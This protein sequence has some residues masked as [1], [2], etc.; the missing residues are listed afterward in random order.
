M[1]P[2]P[3]FFP[4]IGTV[5]PK[6]TATQNP[7]MFLTVTC[8]TASI[9]KS[10]ACQARLASDVEEPASP[11]VS[12]DVPLNRKQYLVAWKIVKEALSWKDHPYDSSKC[13]YRTMASINGESM[14]SHHDSIDKSTW[15]PLSPFRIQS[16]C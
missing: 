13:S 15:A 11:K 5:L 14:S 2:V 4:T 10:W 9:E 1:P 7:A 6:R 16:R 8:I 3:K 12:E